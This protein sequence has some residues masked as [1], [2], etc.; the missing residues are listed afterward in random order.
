MSTLHQSALGSRPYPLDRDRR[1]R[2]MIALA[3]KETNISELAI[4]IG[5]SKAI[6]SK[7]VSGRRFSPKTE[8]RIADFLGKS[9]DDLFPERSIEELVE[10]RKAEASR[11]AAA[12][13]GTAA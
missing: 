4:K 5:I 7:V 11:Q 13:K 2:V 12:R 8:Q 10:M 1:R 6:I 3:E 9:S